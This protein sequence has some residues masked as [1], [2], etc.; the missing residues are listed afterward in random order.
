MIFTHWFIGFLLAF[1]G[2]VTPAML[3]MTTVRTSVEHSIKHGVLFGIG[4]ALINALQSVLSFEFATFLN[5]NPNVINYLKKLGIIILLLLAYYFYRKSQR[6]VKQGK[7]ISSVHPFNK[8]MLLSSI[9]T[10]GLVY[11]FTAGLALQANG[12]VILEMPYII[13]LSLGI[14]SGG[15]VAFTIYAI[16]AETISKKSEFFARNINLILSV[17]FVFLSIFVGISLYL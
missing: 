17:L 4:A 9:N 1:I 2:F 16:L 11:Y 12:K 3:N 10:L 14:F 8:G 6:E 15:S 13:Y 7:K 5:E